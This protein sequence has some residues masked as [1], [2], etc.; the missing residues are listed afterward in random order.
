MTTM[1]VN[2]CNRGKK[3]MNNAATLVLLSVM[4]SVPVVGEAPGSVKDVIIQH[5]L[6]FSSS[7]CRFAVLGA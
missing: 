7:A 1:P 2:K 3:N 6:A 4:L 5:E